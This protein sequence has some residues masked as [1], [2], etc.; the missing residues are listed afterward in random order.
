VQASWI[1]RLNLV[2]ALIVFAL[3]VVLARGGL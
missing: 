2:L 3:G 1:G